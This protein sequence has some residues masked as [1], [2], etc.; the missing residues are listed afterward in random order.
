MTL[1]RQLMQRLGVALALSHEQRC[2]LVGMPAQQLSVAALAPRGGGR[3]GCRADGVFCWRARHVAQR[4]GR[5]GR[6]TLEAAKRLG[7]RTIRVSPGTGKRDEIDRLVPYFK[8]AAEIAERDGIWMGI[9]NHGSEL[10][11]NPEACLEISEK[12]GSK[13]FG[14]LYEP[15]N[16]MAA[17]V[18]YKEAFDIFKDHIVHVHIKDGNYNPDGKW[19]RCMLGDGVIDVQWV[20]DSVEALGYTGEYALEFEVG[21]IEPV[22][23]GYSKWRRYWESL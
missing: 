22:E 12:I 6:A 18:D 17:N 15:S 1:E 23:S 16:L 5:A 9:E 14:I 4:E 20:W 21:K 13:H 3:G 10:S 2:P 8:D 11:G 19:E 7:A